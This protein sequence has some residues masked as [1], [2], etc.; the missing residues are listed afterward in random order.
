MREE[1]ISLLETIFRRFITAILCRRYSAPATWDPTRL[2]GARSRR[3]LWSHLTPGSLSGGLARGQSFPATSTSSLVWPFLV[4]LFP[5][6]NM[7]TSQR[8]QAPPPGART[9]PLIRVR[10]LPATRYRWFPGT[11]RQSSLL[12]GI[13]QSVS[14]HLP[15]PLADPR[16]L[17]GPLCSA[18]N[19]LAESSPSDLFDTC[20]GS[21]QPL[22]VR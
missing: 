19:F 6:R 14:S 17:S 1:Y 4:S 3:P 15:W 22:A 2:A 12:R 16:K 11:P 13:S 18:D 20:S 9:P 8:F 7:A 21:E 10:D 5:R